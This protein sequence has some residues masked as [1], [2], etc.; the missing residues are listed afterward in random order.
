MADRTGGKTSVPQIFVDNK[1]FGG[2][3]ELKEYFKK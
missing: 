3:S 1:Y 2:L